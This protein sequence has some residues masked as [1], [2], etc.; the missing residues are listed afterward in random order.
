MYIDLPLH[1]NT[2]RKKNTKQ[3][4]SNI[5]IMDQ[6]PNDVSSETIKLL[7]A[8]LRRIEHAVCGD[9]GRDALVSDKATVSSRLADLER[10]LHQLSAK[11]KVAQD[12]LKLRTLAQAIWKYPY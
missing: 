5:V 7:E 6:T 10:S 4:C 11:S 2:T 9:I 12:L 1:S 3:A 8:R